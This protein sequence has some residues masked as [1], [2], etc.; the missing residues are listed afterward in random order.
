[1]RSLGEI[2]REFF[3]LF[4]N[5]E[6]IYSKSC[7][8]ISVDSSKR[9]CV[10]EPI[11]DSGKIYDVKLQ[12]VMSSSLGVVLFPKV[13]SFVTVT[14]LNSKTGIVS[15]TEELDNISVKAGGEDL[16]E[17]LDDLLDEINLITV[18]TAWGPSGTPIN[19]AN[20]SAI[21]LRIDKILI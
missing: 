7:K 19:A 15:N 17:I 20:F 1:M 3:K 10:V 5:E 21:K 8:V 16:K 11:D 18:P 14:F 2:I 4:I 6:R 12:S 9:S 13:D